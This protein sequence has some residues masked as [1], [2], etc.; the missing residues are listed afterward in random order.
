M[1]APSPTGW[2]TRWTTPGA[3]WGLLA[4]I[5]VMLVAATGTLAWRIAEQARPQ[6]MAASP[7]AQHTPGARGGALRVG[8]SG[9]CISL[10]RRAA[11][12]CAQAGQPLSVR[13]E[14]GIGS[15][16][17]LAALGDGLLDVAVVSRPLKT[18]EQ[19]PGRVVVPY[20]RAAIAV[21][22]QADVVAPGLTAT[23]LRGL[24]ADERAAWPD[25]TPALWLLR[26]SR[27]SGHEAL[28][29]QWPGFAELES[30]A[31]ARPAAQVLFH[32]RTMHAA[33]QSSRGA[34]G[35]VDATAVRAERSPLQ[36][37][38]VDGVAPDAAALAAGRWPWI[39]DLA[40]V[41]DDR[42]KLEP[43]LTCLRSAPGRA[44]LTAAGALTLLE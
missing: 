24:M 27:D 32:D 16:G 38:M 2:A 31:R 19:A 29:S 39:K 36:L 26:E 34:W 42:A 12:A 28:R 15:G 18:A 5:G 33:L 17:G 37:L 21:A 22:T 44:E 7:P 4:L 1:T 14:E 8:G 20:A 13:V 30:R 23:A 40:I 11:R 9:S 10:L 41:A 25:G 6:F 3:L 43:L 35:F